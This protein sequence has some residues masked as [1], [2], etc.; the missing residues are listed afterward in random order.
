MNFCGFCGK[1]PFPTKSGLNKHI[2][3]SVSCN[4]DGRQKWGNYA[5]NIWDNSPCPSNIEGQPPASPP[6]LEDDEVQNMPDIT[7][8][9]DLQRLEEEV[10][11]VG[12]AEPD[13]PPDNTEIR[14]HQHGILQAT[15]E[16]V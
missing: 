10:A 9:D 16:D 7:L 12:G 3:Q 2:G 8:E 1:G 14:P 13:I 4:K 11:N 6:I 15:F 5:T